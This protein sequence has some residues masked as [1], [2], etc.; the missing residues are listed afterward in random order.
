MRGAMHGEDEPVYT[1][2]VAARILGVSAQLLRSLEREG[3]VYPARTS[4][5]TRLYSQNEL[6]ILHRICVLLKDQKVNLAGIKII[7][8]LERE[9]GSE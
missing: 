8:T 9:Q 7:L 3:L 6:I 5:N 1:I 2:G 4:S